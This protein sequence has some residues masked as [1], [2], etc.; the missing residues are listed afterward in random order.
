MKDDPSSFAASDAWILLAIVYAS[1][2]RAADLTRI[3]AAADFINHAILTYP[4]L[5]NGLRRLQVVGLIHVHRGR[6]RADRKV[7]KAYA[8]RSTPRRAALQELQDMQE[9]LAHQPRQQAVPRL[10][11]RL[12]RLSRIAYETAIRNYTNV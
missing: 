9:F 7:L 2:R 10:R 3:I 4:E 11:L 8:R 12:K 6:Y 5:R 1:H